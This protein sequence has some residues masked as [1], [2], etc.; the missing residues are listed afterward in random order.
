MSSFVN[1]APFN[2]QNNDIITNNSYNSKSLNQG[3][4][5]KRRT[6][7]KKD[8][9][10]SISQKIKDIWDSVEDDSDEEGDNY[11][12]PSKP[13]FTPPPAPQ[14]AELNRKPL[15]QENSQESQRPKTNHLE[16]PTPTSTP[17]NS[18]APVNVEGFNTIDN[19]SEI[20]N[21]Q[22]YKQYV[23]YYNNTNN[24]SMNRDELMEKMNKVIQLLE[25]QQDEKS[26]NVTEELVLYCFLGVFV[27]FVVDSFAR[28]GKY[29]R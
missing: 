26:N 5:N 19:V 25:D 6:I 29:T 14:L 7:K 23:P 9:N 20:A 15:E 2:E 28:A 10:T 24:E 27:I 8:N 4:T 21:E 12:P 13:Q 16:T 11:T 18:D 1:A 17:E 3:S 22:Y